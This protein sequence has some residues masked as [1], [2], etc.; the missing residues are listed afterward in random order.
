M[1]RSS[2]DY[3]ARVHLYIEM[4]KLRSFAASEK[5]LSREWS[6]VW[7]TSNELYALLKPAE[8]KALKEEG[9]G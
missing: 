7:R 4:L 1:P 2:R 8:R 6:V 3:T 5:S 9:W